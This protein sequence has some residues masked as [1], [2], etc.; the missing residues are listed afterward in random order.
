MERVESHVE[1][2]DVEQQ[3]PREIIS[4]PIEKGE[5]EDLAI[6]YFY[7]CDGPQY[8]RQWIETLLEDASHFL[9]TFII[10][11][12]VGW[13][14]IDR[15]DEDGKRCV[16]WFVVIP[17]I[18]KTMCTLLHG[19]GCWILNM[20]SHFPFLEYETAARTK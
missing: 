4:I 5:K 14:P 8:F 2:G 11:G 12:L 20:H 18:E 9:F 6:N 15:N 19:T 3:I 13:T 16:E 10:K 1:D 7:P 17:C